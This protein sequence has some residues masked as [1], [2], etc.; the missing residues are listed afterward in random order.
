MRSII[1]TTGGAGATEPFCFFHC[2]R[3]TMNHERPLEK[4]TG[5]I[6]DCGDCFSEALECCMACAASA[7]T[8]PL[9]S[10]V[11]TSRFG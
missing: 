1:I 6:T 8:A 11:V 7:W 2:C 5:R 10:V 3:P 4:G 9:L